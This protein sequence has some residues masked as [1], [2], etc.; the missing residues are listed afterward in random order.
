MIDYRNGLKPG[1]VM[2]YGVV[3]ETRKVF[4]QARAE[5]RDWYYA[6]NS[7]FDRGRQGYF[8]VTKNAFQLTEL[9]TPDYGR[10]DSLGVKI[11]VWRSEGDYV[12]L[13]EQS[14]AFMRL[15]GYEGDWVDDA[16]KIVRGVTE[17][18]IRVRHWD[19]DKAKMMKTLREDLAKAWAVVTHMSASANEALIC[20][21]P[22]FLTGECAATPMRCGELSD[23]DSPKYSKGRS[24]WAAGLAA[25]QW[26]VEEIRNGKCWRD[27]NA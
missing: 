13:C 14:Q 8:R 9:A 4:E 24:A 5:G 10:L 2:F 23:I 18:E 3:D 6:D 21:V 22:V 1:A 27:L 15:C 19:R 11:K 25:N 26:T 17:R 7:Y 16:I 20:G 12:L